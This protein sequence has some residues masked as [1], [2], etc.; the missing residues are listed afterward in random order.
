M[1]KYRLWCTVEL[2]LP[3]EVELDESPE[4]LTDDEFERLTED[5]D[6]ASGLSEAEILD[7]QVD[8]WEPIEE[9]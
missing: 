8:D 4:D 7:F 6:L 3:V 5:A 9:A 1:A 2:Y